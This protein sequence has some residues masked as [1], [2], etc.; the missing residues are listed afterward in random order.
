VRLSLHGGDDRG[1]I[2]SD[3]KEGAKEVGCVSLLD[4]YLGEA[5][6]RQWSGRTTCLY[7]GCEPTR[8]FLARFREEDLNLLADEGLVDLLRDFEPQSRE[9]A[10]SF[11]H[12]PSDDWFDIWAAGVPARGEK[13]VT[14]T[15][16]GRIR[17]MRSIVLSN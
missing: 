1:E 14:F 8:S 5:S 16:S 13:R 6:Q 10:R 4:P 11:L 17:P 7:S 9:P 12:A 3:S 15:M 2:R